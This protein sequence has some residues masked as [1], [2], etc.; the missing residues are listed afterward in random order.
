[1]MEAKSADIE[2]FDPTKATILCV[3]D[4]PN[5]LSALKRLFRSAGYQIH[6][7]QSGKDGLWVLEE[8][9]VDVV[10]SDMRMPEMDGAAF[11]EKV[12]QRWP[13][14]VRIL[15]TGQADLTSTVN[16][17][18]K[19][20]IYRY[21]SKP[22]EDNDLKLT[23]KSG[24]ETKYLE[25]ERRRLEKLTYQQNEQL[26]ELNSRLED[27]VTERTNE[28]EQAMGFL[29]AAH[30]SLKESYALAIKVFA[31]LIEAREPGLA[32]HARRVG[33]LSQRFAMHIGMGEHD[34]Q[35]ILYAGILHD[36]GKIAL[37]DELLVKPI[38]SLSATELDEVSKHPV[39]AQGVLMALDPLQGAGNIIHSHHERY[40]GSG[41]PGRLAGDAIPVGAR[42]LSIVNDYDSLQLGTVDGKNYSDTEA[43]AW[44][45]S[46]AARYYDPE[47]V[48]QFMAF[49]T[50]V[51]L[52][53]I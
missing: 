6:T 47:L 13:N 33:D 44:I 31:N 32:G 30:N 50:A 26:M 7:A 29:D 38:E 9:A 11:L 15:L 14:T 25:Q 4:E 45:K 8:N 18:N 41:Y 17:V 24:L 5:I 34:A 36:I 46:R 28:L 1:M 10:I 3:D 23:I 37:R 2:G 20:G 43:L 48:K 12:T 22:W 40:D 21:V 27:K 16:A 52:T 35:D 53:G 51:P 42:V 19:G 49:I 39:I